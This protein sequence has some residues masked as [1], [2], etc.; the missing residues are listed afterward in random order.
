MKLK[1]IYNSY[2]LN[3]GETL[4]FKLDFSDCSCAVRLMVRKSVE[5]QKFEKC[6]IE[7]VFR[8]VANIEISEDF[9]TK[10]GFSDITLTKTSDGN[11]YLSLD[12]YGN[13]NEPHDNDNFIIVGSS[14]T[15]KFDN[16][17]KFDVS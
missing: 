15:V 14:L 2:A 13:T 6:E 3:D 4:S 7:F 5:N 1:D 8:G 10:G 17:E 16:G 12:P 11:F 9:G